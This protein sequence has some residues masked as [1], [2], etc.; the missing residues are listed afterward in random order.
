MNALRLTVLKSLLE[1]LGF[2]TTEGPTSRIAFPKRTRRRSALLFPDIKK[3]LGVRLPELQA[4]LL[5]IG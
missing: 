3:C 1:C 4:L 2:A 5:A